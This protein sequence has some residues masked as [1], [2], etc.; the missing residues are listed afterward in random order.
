MRVLTATVV[1][2]AAMLLAPGQAVAG[3]PTSVLL[4][5]PNTGSTAA[6]YYSDAEYDQLQRALGQ[7][8]SADDAAPGLRGG[9][10]T[11]AI[12]ITWL[13]HDVHVWRV[14]RVFVDLDGGPWVETAISPSGDP[15][16]DSP[17]VLHRAS[18][19][20]LLRQLLDQLGLLG[21][22][23]AKAGTQPAP[24]DAAQQPAAGDAAQQPARD[25][26]Q[27][28]AAQQPAARDAAPRPAAVSTAESQWWL[29]V[30]ALAAGALLGA[31][32]RPAVVLAI[33]TR[34]GRSNRAADAG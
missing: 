25:A 3:G 31:M 30:F 33:R 9:P 2:A 26:A 10:G 24:A 18:D 32:L 7:N 12:N 14:D 16:V 34:R 21:N 13:V 28:D 4:V 22:A 29:L 1:A 5:S 8:P 17:G 6:L 23:P 27:Q 15:T 11:T 19:P 20:A